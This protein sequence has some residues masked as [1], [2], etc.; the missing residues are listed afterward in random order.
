MFNSNTIL[1]L[2]YYS[3]GKPFTGSINGKRYRIMMFKE[4]SKEENNEKKYLKL[5]IYPEPFSFENTDES[6]MEISV[7]DFSP[8][9]YEEL[10]KY[11]NDYFS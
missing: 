8:E 9:G 6:L 2:N 11:L 3:Y 4:G 1:S 7:F 10:L 5:W